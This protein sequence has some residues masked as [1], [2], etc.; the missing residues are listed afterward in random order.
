MK[1]FEVW[2]SGNVQGV[3]FRA[4]TQDI[5]KQYAVSGYV[6][7][8]HDG[9]VHLFAQGDHAEIERFLAAVSER[10]RSNINAVEQISVPV[11]QDL[12]GFEIR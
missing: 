2:Y 1:A 4:N 11:D 7:N 6:Q 12:D 10:M 5:S 9:R 3:F 8:L